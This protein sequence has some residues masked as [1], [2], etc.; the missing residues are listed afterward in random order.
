M[1]ETSDE[2]KQRVGTVDVGVS[3]D[4]R[5]R[6]QVLRDFVLAIALGIGFVVVLVYASLPE[7]QP[8]VIGLPLF[9]GYCALAYFLRVRPN[10]D[11]VGAFGGVVDNPLRVSDGANRGLVQLALALAIGRYISCGLVDG[12]YLL[13]TGQLPQERFM[14]R[15]DRNQ[16]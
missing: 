12:F 6:G 14:Q 16:V 13:K 1:L 8:I 5:S 2:F 4:F 3:L 11:E 10:H 15:L 9:V 7:L